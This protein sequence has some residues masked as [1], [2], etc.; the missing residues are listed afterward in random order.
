MNKKIVIHIGKIG[1]KLS[2]AIHR[3]FTSN[4]NRM[5]KKIKGCPQGVKTPLFFCF[6]YINVLRWWVQFLDDDIKVAFKVFVCFKHFSNFVMTVYNSSMVAITHNFSDILERLVGI[7][8]GKI[9][10]NLSWISDFFIFLLRNDVRNRNIIV[11][12][13]DIHNQLWSYLF[14]TFN[15]IF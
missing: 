15:R 10:T 3:Q 8:T 13:N 2:T 5:W 12:G 11:F 7:F 6:F 4:L 1:Q 14:L 9:H